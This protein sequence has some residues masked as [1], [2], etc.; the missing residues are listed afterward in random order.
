MVN[1][2]LYDQPEGALIWWPVI[3][4]VGERG[5][6]P[7]GIWLGGLGQ[8]NVTRPCSKHKYVNFAPL[9][10]RKCCN[11]LA[12]PRPWPSNLPYSKQQNMFA[13]S[14]ISLKSH[15]IREN[16]VVEGRRRFAGTTPFRHKN[17]RCNTWLLKIKI[18]I[19]IFPRVP[20]MLQW[21]GHT[22]T[23]VCPITSII[24]QISFV[25]IKKIEYKPDAAADN[26][27]CFKHYNASE[28]GI[29][30]NECHL[31]S[32]S[33][34]SLFFIYLFIY[35]FFFGGGEGLKESA[36]VCSTVWYWRLH[37]LPSWQHVRCME[38]Q[39]VAGGWKSA[40]NQMKWNH[41]VLIPG[42]YGKDNGGLVPFFCLLLAHFQ[43]DR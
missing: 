4:G 38:W 26:V 11:V 15:K 43:G 1:P 8:L 31:I 33:F 39:S 16:Y 28:V 41:F 29:M 5:D 20:I 37:G 22:L 23:H 2:S 21:K 35:L 14:C 18:M 9:S 25:G 40:L 27:L 30:L 32:Y 6:C 13:F 19:I 24:M 42:C 3:L 12:C 10:K 17:V 34:I 36:W 7:T